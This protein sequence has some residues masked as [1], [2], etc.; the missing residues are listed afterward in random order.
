MPTIIIQLYMVVNLISSPPS[1]SFGHGVK[2]CAKSIRSLGLLQPGLA[3][4]YESR[5]GQF[6][7]PMVRVGRRF[8]VTS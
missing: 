2:Y 4:G 5:A 1:N 7:I 6:E 8:F 3:S